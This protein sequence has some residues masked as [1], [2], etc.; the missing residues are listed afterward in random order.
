MSTATAPA[1]A[2]PVARNGAA[3]SQPVG[4]ALLHSD[5]PEAALR[6]IDKSAYGVSGLTDINDAFLIERLHQCGL[7]VEPGVPS[8]E[9]I[10][11][12]TVTFKRGTP[13]EYEVHE[14]VVSCEW[15]W[16][17]DGRSWTGSGAHQDARLDV[18]KKGAKTSAFKDMCKYLAMG[19]EVRKAGKV[20]DPQ[21]YEGQ[22]R[23]SGNGRNFDSAAATAR[24][25]SAAL[26]LGKSWPGCGDHGDTLVVRL[27]RNGD[28]FLACS[29]EG[30]E[31]RV[32]TEKIP[33]ELITAI[34]AAPVAP[35]D[36]N[37]VDPDDIPF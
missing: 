28:P 21:R 37:D 13:N 14:W 16:V 10:G 23:R 32:W 20:V 22:G 6:P 11:K 4:W 35:S 26:D 15:T 30:C 29:Q 2:Q 1:P 25:K 12:E 17:V 3:G 8:V 27:K 34:T 5:L 19:L 7:S 18:A 31:R 9:I 24:G 36:P 33:A